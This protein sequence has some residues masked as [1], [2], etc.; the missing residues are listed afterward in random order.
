M[1]EREAV[2][3]SSHLAENQPSNEIEIRPDPPPPL[4]PFLSPSPP[5]VRFIFPAKVAITVVDFRLLWDFYDRSV[6]GFQFG[7]CEGAEGE[8]EGIHLGW[9][10]TTEEVFFLAPVVAPSPFLP[11]L[12]NLVRRLLP[13]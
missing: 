7:F 13:D 2:A 6:V 4:S 11:P 10:R 12:C 5:L 1:R 8:K 3:V 9:P